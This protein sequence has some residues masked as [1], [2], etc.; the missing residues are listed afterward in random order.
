MFIGQRGGGDDAGFLGELGLGQH[1]DD[2]HISTFGLDGSQY[3]LKVLLGPTRAG[4]IS[5]DVQTEHEIGHGVPSHRWMARDA[6]ERNSALG[7]RGR[8]PHPNELMSR[9]RKQRE[10]YLRKRVKTTSGLVG[11][12][13]SREPAD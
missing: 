8:K 7:Y 6:G 5:G 9:R 13:L 1:V 10:Q 4:R 2:L 12:Y 11:I 3:V